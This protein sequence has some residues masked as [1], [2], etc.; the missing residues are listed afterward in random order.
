MDKNKFVQVVNVN[1]I[2]ASDI[3]LFV[4]DLS[5]LGGVGTLGPNIEFLYRISYNDP[6]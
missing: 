4:F 5:D 1:V 3:M 6:F 2:P